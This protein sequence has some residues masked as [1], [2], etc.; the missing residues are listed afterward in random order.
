MAWD[1][2]EWQIGLD[3]QRAVNRVGPE[4]AR[5]LF[6]AYPDWGVRIL[7]APL[8]RVP[9][10]AARLVEGVS[11]ARASNAWVVGGERTRSGKPILAN[12]MHLALRAP[13]LWYLAALHGGGIDVAG[14]TIPGIPVVIAGHS[15]RVAWGY[16]NAMLDD[17]DY[18]VERVDPADSTRYRVPG[19]WARFAVRA[20]TIRVK[21]AEPVVHRV[22]ASRHGPILSDVED[23]AAGQVLAMRWTALDPSEDF[24]A[25]YAMNRARSAAE[26]VEALPSFRT[27]HQNVVFA[28][29]EG[30]IGYWMAGRVPLRPTREALLPLPGWTGEHDWRGYL[31]WAEHPHAL[32]PP[33]GFVVT[34][35]NRQAGP[36]YP[37]FIGDNFAAPYRAMRIREMVGA[38]GKLTAEEVLRQQMDVRDL[39]A[40]RYLPLAARAAESAG[41]GSAAALLRGWDAEARPG[42]R[43]AALFYAWYE[44]LRHRVGDDEFRGGRVYFPRD[45]LDRVLDGAGEAWLDDVRTPARETLPELS[46]AAMRAAVATVGGRAW[47]ELHATRIEHPLGSAAALDRTLSLN[48]GPFPSGGSPHT[49]NVALYGGRPP[50]VTTHGPSQRHVVDLG[51]PDGAGGFVVPTGQSGIPFSAHYRDQAPLWREG[52]LWRIPLAREQASAR[53]VARLRLN[54]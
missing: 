23:R 37:H 4:L 48:L 13:S 16:T 6:P 26:L 51:D 10:L 38:G 21:G 2:A 20:E 29:A 8:P 17:V 47:G 52:R 15:R 30:R 42:S 11:M 5:T 25:M 12:D 3:L 35:N 1:L 24:R 33:A 27:P 40:A 18:F 44:E 9:P 28:D 19:G 46:A 54:P 14:M 53:T 45:A 32:D 31:P 34:A 43:A 7:D 22:R 39:H 41:E 50:F 36:E 49:V